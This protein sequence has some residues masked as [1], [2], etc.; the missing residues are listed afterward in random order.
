MK[1][2]KWLTGW[3]VLVM[4]MLVVIGG[5]V[6]KVDPYF[7]YHKPDTKKYYYLLYNQR[8][9][10]D[11]ISR[12]FD[13]DALITGTSMVE[14]FKTS[15]F[16]EEFGVN[17][18]KVPYAGASYK[19]INDNLVVALESN[20]ELKTIIRCLDYNKF[21]DDKDLIRSDLGQY[22]DYLYDR[23]PFNDVYYLFNRDVIFD[24]VFVMTEEAKKEG[25]APGITSFDKY[26]RWQEGYTFGANSVIP[27]GIAVTLPQEQ[28]HLTE[29]EKDVIYGN[30]TQNVTSLA[31]K[32]PDVDFYYFF[33]PYSAAWWAEAVSDG[34]IYKWTE[35]EEY[36]IELILDHENIKLYSFNNCTEITTNLNY[37]K[38]TIHY[39]EWINSFMLK[40]MRDGAYLLTG[41]N[42][43]NYIREELDFYTTFDYNSL[44]EQEE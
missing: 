30:I 16:D 27:E 44:N 40:A 20:S 35:A 36:I 43:K 21:F 22:P 42:Y 41:E 15:E 9:Q 34:T 32:Y 14:N 24:R 10:N 1:S 37:Y 29:E 7:H 13:Y 38:D 5:F 28:V 6:Y 8:S 3:F 11:G 39:G 2:K 33:S 31:E 26:S 19:E 18:I 23:N 12:H 25:F 4:T 17:S